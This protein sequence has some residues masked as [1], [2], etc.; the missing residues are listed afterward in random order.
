[1]HRCTPDKPTPNHA[2]LPPKQHPNPQDLLASFSKSEELEESEA[3]K[4]DACGPS[5][6]ASKR[7]RVWACPPAALV[8]TL[9]RFASAG[10]RFC[11]ARK[12]TTP[13]ALPAGGALDLAP[14]CNPRGLKER[15]ARGWPRPVYRLAAVANH[16]GTLGGG[17]PWGLLFWGGG[18][19]VAGSERGRA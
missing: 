2:R 11:A 14:Y 3:Y 7:L 19:A 4:C 13:V 10:G 1:M 12:V 18:A 9:K 15:A 16:S 6:P 5:Q 8:I 17:A